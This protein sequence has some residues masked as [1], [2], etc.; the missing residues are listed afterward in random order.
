MTA[1]PRIA[2][3]YILSHPPASPEAIR[4]IIEK[5]RQRAIEL[6][7]RQVGDLVALT[8]EQDIRAS[9]YGS[10]PIPP[11]AVVYFSAA[12]FDSDLAE[13][14]LCSEPVEIEIAG[15]TIPYGLDEWTWSGSIRTR[16]VKTLSELFDFAAASLGLWASMTF[17]GM[18]ISCFRGADG[19]VEYDQEWIEHPEGF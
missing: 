7:L 10:Q 18:T 12:L 3:S 17:A 13:F 8:T 11:D 19:T 4:E 2:V 16:D 15:T 1:D 14:G 6:G 5:L 9:R